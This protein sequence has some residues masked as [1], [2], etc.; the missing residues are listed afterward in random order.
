MP[1]PNFILLHVANPAVSASFYEGLLGRPP[2]EASPNFVMFALD[3]GM[4]LG[5]WAVPATP[6]GHELAFTVDDVDATC[7]DWTARGI[8]I[9]NPPAD[10][11]FGRTFLAA[12]PDGHLLRVLRPSA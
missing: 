12:D 4:M 2:V 8:T 1:S 7:A 6:G 9:L 11:D 5:L 3:G 10:L